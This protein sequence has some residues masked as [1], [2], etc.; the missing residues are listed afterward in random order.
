MLSALTPFFSAWKARMSSTKRRATSSGNSN[1]LRGI[2]L[3]LGPPALDCESWRCSRSV[4]PSPSVDADA[5]ICRVEHIVARAL[6]LTVL[7]HPRPRHGTSS[8]RATIAGSGTA[9][10]GF[11]TAVAGFGLVVPGP[12]VTGTG[13]TRAWGVDA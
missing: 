7:V 13:V 12:T 1:S 10:A 8:P 2:G 3:I 4:V 9:V 11:G 5:V 6:Q